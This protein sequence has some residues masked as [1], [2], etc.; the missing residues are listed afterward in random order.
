MKRT[1]EIPDGVNIIVKN[2]EVSV[3]GTK[4]E[5]SR[6]FS[7]P[8][9]NSKITIEKNYKELLFTS[10]SEKK[11]DRAV[12]GTIHA[13]VKNMVRGVKEGYEYKM[14]IFYS[15]FPITLEIKGDKIMIKNFLGEKSIR[16]ARIIGKTKVEVKK[17]DVILTGI[18]REDI[19]NTASNIERACRIGRKD[20]RIFFD[21]IYLSK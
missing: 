6:D 8:R 10:T 4:G 5:I 14:T 21:G 13:H 1:Y 2:L 19:G 7:D 18:N 17:N 15:H 12:L 9:Y 16:T 11:K 20:R 3:K